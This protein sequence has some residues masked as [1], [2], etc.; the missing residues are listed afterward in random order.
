M[1][2][3]QAAAMVGILLVSTSRAACQASWAACMRIH[4][5]GPSPN[6]LPS[7]TATTGETGFRSLDDVVEM[8]AGDPEK[9]GDL[10]LGPTGCGDHDFTQKLHRVGGASIGIA[11]GAV[12]DHDLFPQ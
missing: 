8:L 3:G 4:T 6:S 2:D 11:G 9:R 10:F 1:C 7:R 5:P 12:L